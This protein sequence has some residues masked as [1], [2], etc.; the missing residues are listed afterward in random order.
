MLNNKNKWNT[1]HECIQNYVIEGS[2]F[3]EFYNCF[4]KLFNWIKYTEII[5]Y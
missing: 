2:H 4:L 1:S 5:I 3:N